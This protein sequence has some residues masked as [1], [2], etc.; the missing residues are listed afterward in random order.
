MKRTLGRV[1]SLP[2]ALEK[3]E[4]FPFMGMACELDRGG[5]HLRRHFQCCV[6]WIPLSRFTKQHRNNKQGPETL[7]LVTQSPRDIH[8]KQT[9]SGIFTH[10][11][12]ALSL[13]SLASSKY[14]ESSSFNQKKYNQNENPP[15]GSNMNIEPNHNTYMHATSMPPNP[16]LGRRSIPTPNRKR[17]SPYLDTQCRRPQQN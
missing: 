2:R 5:W 9:S 1:Q 7:V 14:Y 13:G 8:S 3:I 11:C 6:F 16:Q 4:T 12:N 10:R 17:H 15:K